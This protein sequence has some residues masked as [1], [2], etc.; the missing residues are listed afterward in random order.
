MN[1]NFIKQTAKD[2][3]LKLD[4]VKNIYQKYPDNFYIEL[5][6]YLKEQRGK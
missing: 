4:I 1:K 5:E 2:Y 3:D 6:K